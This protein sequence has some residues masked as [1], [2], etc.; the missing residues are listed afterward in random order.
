MIHNL[1]DIIPC[2]KKTVD[3]LP[4]NMREEMAKECVPTAD[5]FT[6]DEL[7]HI[8]THL[9]GIS[10]QFLTVL[11]RLFIQALSMTGIEFCRVAGSRGDYINHLISENIDRGDYIQSYL[12]KYAIYMVGSY[13]E[14]PLAVARADSLL[15]GDT[16]VTFY[17]DAPNIPP[18]Y[19]AAN[20]ERLLFLACNFEDRL[21]RFRGSGNDQGFLQAL[22]E[23][24]DQLAANDAERAF[25]ANMAGQVRLR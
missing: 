19:V 3:L 18:E 6:S 4:V 17:H 9:P 21:H 20:T 7:D 5:A 16:V 23:V 2:C 25:W 13:G 8:R 12:N 14:E 11:S 15:G 22:R 10:E 1:N 24:F